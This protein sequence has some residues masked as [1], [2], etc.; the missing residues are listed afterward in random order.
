MQING[1]WYVLSVR[2]GWEKRAEI[3]LRAKEYE[4]LSP[5]SSDGAS[6]RT[7]SQR[8]CIPIFPGY[9]FLR[10]NSLSDAKILTTPGVLRIVSFGG[11]WAQVDEREIWSVRRVIER[12]LFRQ[13]C[14]YPPIG[15]QV[16]VESGPFKGVEG[17]IIQ[18]SKRLVI[19]VSLIQRAMAVTFDED[20]VVSQI[21]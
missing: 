13:S 3:S 5:L 18:G 4:V 8:E 10:F 12:N 17:K 9:L 21:S 15:T 2:A 20:T 19:C 14:S 6:R 1:Q 11:R 16:R 7:P